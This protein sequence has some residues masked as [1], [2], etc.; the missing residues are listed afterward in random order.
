MISAIFRIKE[1]PIFS[2][3]FLSIFYVVG[4][5]GINFFPE[6]ILPYSFMILLMNFVFILIFEENL[7]SAKIKFFLFVF[8]ASFA[9]EMIGVG[10]GKIFGSY[11]YGNSLG[12]T[13]KNVP[14]IIGINWLVLV[15]G[16]IN[17]ISKFKIN[18]DILFA[19]S[20]GILMVVLDVLMEKVAPVLDYWNFFGELA[21][22]KN[23]IAWFTISFFFFF[24][25]RAMNLKAENKIASFIYIIQFIFFV[26]VNIIFWNFTL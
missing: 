2:K 1:H 24:L 25:F 16:I 20:G 18:N 8:A 5:F 9:I 4:I 3:I 17:I 22:L 11:Y 21:P 15:L 7:D 12:F 13:L 23:Y 10:S 6:K 14:I 26:A 19:I